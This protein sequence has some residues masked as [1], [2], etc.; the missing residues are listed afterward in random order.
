MYL[1]MSL[2]AAILYT[3]GGISMKLSDGFSQLLPSLFI[4]LCFIGGASLQTL[5]MRK[6]DLGV[7]YILVLGIESIS[8]LLFGIL[9]FKENYSLTKLLGVSL[10]VTGIIFLHSRS[11]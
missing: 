9:I 10:I 1:L 7:A 2:A 11:S 5:V 8:A 6:A 4:Y 3:V